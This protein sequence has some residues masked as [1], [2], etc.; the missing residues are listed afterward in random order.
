[1]NKML[2][3]YIHIPYCVRKCPYCGFYS[4]PYTSDGADDFVNA[5]SIEAA[6]YQAEFSNRRFHTIYVGGGTPTALSGDQIGKVLDIARNHFEIA[7]GAEITVEANPNTV[8]KDLL[9]RLL[10]GGANRL[11]IGVQSYSDEV[12]HKLGRLHTSMEAEQALRLARS[13]GFHNI[14]TDLIYGI[15]GQT[16]DQWVD[17]LKTSI[18]CMPEHVSIYSL[19]LDEG[20]LFHEM[21]ETGNFEY[22]DD[23]SAAEMYE[24]AISAFT[25]AG[26]H[27]Y[28]ISNL[29]QPGFE[30]RH[31]RNYWSRGEYLGL[32][33]GAW[34]F[35]SPRR[36]RNIA[37]AGEY[38]RRL[39]DGITPVTESE[40]AGPEQASRETI[41]LSLR[42]AEGLDLQRYQS[43]Y[44]SIFSKKLEENMAP[45]VAAG[46]IVVN[47]R[48]ATLTKR[49]FLL[50]N[51]ALVRLST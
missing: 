28:E 45:L 5:L 7:K 44:G 6:R 42:T 2:S 40:Q 35:I 26:Y 14:G 39:V 1:M 31:N 4:T 3:L 51:E 20:S 15:P 43:E 24:Y 23:D 16:T 34:S 17:T 19:S 46:L 29:S 22:P 49:G 48:R 10:E 38:A 32:G 47:E 36:Y 8:T 30:C 11:S 9:N 50:S 12:L 21:S 41:L 33:P 27:Q 13:A 25:R 37:D 18:Q